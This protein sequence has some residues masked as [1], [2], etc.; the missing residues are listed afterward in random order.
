MGS[1]YLVLALY[2]TLA[3]SIPL[4]KRQDGFGGFDGGSLASNIDFSNLGAQDF[5][6][7]Q[8]SDQTF[9]SPS[10][11]S[12]FA[13]GGNTGLFNLAAT[14]LNT[15]DDFHL[16]GN[17][18]APSI[19]LAKGFD[20]TG[21]TFSNAPGVQLAGIHSTTPAPGN[22]GPPI[23]APVNPP[24]NSIVNSPAVAAG[25]PPVIAPVTTAGNPPVI[26]PVNPT[27]E[28]PAAAPVIA[29]VNPTPESPTPQTATPG[30]SSGDQGT[31][32]A[33]A[34]LH[35]LDLST[36]QPS[37]DDPTKDSSQKTAGSD[38]SVFNSNPSGSDKVTASVQDSGS[39]NTGKADT[40]AGS[41]AATPGGGGSGSKT[42]TPNDSNDGQKPSD[43]S[44]AKVSTDAKT[45]DA[46]IFYTSD[47][48]T[49]DT[50][51]K[52]GSGSESGTKTTYSMTNSPATLSNYEQTETDRQAQRLLQAQAQ[53]YA[54]NNPNVQRVYS[55][56]S[57]TDKLKN[58]IPDILLSVAGAVARNYLQGDQTGYGN[59]I[60]YLEAQQRINAKLTDQQKKDAEEANQKKL[61]AALQYT[62][63][64]LLNTI[65][66]LQKKLTDYQASLPKNPTPAQQQEIQANTATLKQQISDAQSQ[67]DLAKDLTVDQ[68]A[69]ALQSPSSPGTAGTSPTTAQYNTASVA[70][71]TD[72]NAGNGED[73]E[74]AAELAREQAA[75]QQSTPAGG[76]TTTA[77]RCSQTCLYVA[78]DFNIQSDADAAA[79]TCQSQGCPLG[80]WFPCAHW[81]VLDSPTDDLSR[82]P[83]PLQC[84]TR[85]RSS[86][87]R[88]CISERT[89]PS[90]RGTWLFFV[91]TGW[92]C[93]W[94][95]TAALS[96]RRQRRSL[97]IGE[98]LRNV[99][100]ETQRGFD[101]ELRT[102]QVPSPSHS[103]RFERA[104]VW[105]LGLGAGFEISNAYLHKCTSP[106]ILFQW[107][108]FLLNQ[109]PCW[110]L[111]RIGHLMPHDGLVSTR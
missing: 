43:S 29:A 15:G 50:T 28:A 27:P 109:K 35:G 84:I 25:N 95:P 67:Y 97:H 38:T 46:S 71:A 93:V 53:T 85:T 102:E 37:T 8:I 101:G 45:P 49:S 86:P 23:I 89:W 78:T 62:Q 72:P 107:T 42:P 4:G 64:L 48:S 12:T 110:F 79:R 74:T 13:Q 44:G 66:R 51:G 94:Q 87:T 56:P 21:N 18:I 36:K 90:F 47:S 104:W 70:G 91:R 19:D 39:G 88:K 32:V 76:T 100:R 40:A 24:L 106:G 31:K 34:D 6:V 65:A 10:G 73:P 11:D 7:A 111:V 58:G 2:G 92:A 3:L 96:Q 75:S 17:S 20:P 77:I 99:R 80:V 41:D 103:I 108:L 63:K 82:H 5:S 54:S 81:H 22:T 105:F 98:A 9:S 14:P 57:F 68:Y 55:T 60:K 59:Q 26:A 69:A 52:S 1:I 33:T 61:A 83:L 16:S 30:S